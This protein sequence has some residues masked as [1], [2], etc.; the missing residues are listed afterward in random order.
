M[1]EQPFGDEPPDD[2]PAGHCLY[3]EPWEPRPCGASAT[4]HGVTSGP[5]SGEACDKHRD[6]L[7]FHST[8]VHPLGPGVCGWP[9]R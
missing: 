1:D 3:Q 2:L 5:D 4:V 9:V 8:W 7:E 6:I